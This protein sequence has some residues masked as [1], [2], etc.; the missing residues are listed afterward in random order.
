MRSDAISIKYGGLPNPE[1]N[2]EIFVDHFAVALLAKLLDLRW[3]IHRTHVPIMFVKPGFPAGS[4]VEHYR[5]EVC[6][7]I[8][9]LD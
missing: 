2:K 3:K 4:R 5:I 1:K 8:V 6:A 9:G 7:S